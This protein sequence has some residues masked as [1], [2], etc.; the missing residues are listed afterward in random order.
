MS[1]DDDVD[2]TNPRPKGHY[3]RFRDSPWY[4]VND[5]LAQTF[6]LGPATDAEPGDDWILSFTGEGVTEADRE[7][8]CVRLT[9]RALHE[10]YIETKDLS[11]DAR[12]AGHTAECDLCGESV[13]LEKAIPNPRQEPV[14]RYCYVDAYG[15]PTWL[16]D[17]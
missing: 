3:G 8:V 7:R 10:L 17:Y 2:P 5:E 1:D 13:P 9:P 11:P 16:E 4:Y 14:H 6:I 15:G 12:Q